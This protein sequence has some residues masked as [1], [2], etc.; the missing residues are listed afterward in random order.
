LES[1]SDRE[2]N[3]SQPIFNG[4]LGLQQRVVPVYR[5]PFFEALGRACRDGLSVFAG[6]PLPQENIQSAGRLEGIDFTAGEN[7]HLFDPS[8]PF[9]QCWQPGLLAWLEDR[10]P[11]VLVVEANPRYPTTRQ[12]IRWM[13]NRGRKVL[14]W[15][16]GAPPLDGFLAGWRRKSRLALLS[17]LD[18]LIAYS[19]RGALEYQALSPPTSQVFVAPNAVTF[20]PQHPPPQRLAVFSDRPKILFVGRL[21]ERKRI[22]LLFEACARLPEARQPDVWIV[23][24]GPAAGH[25]KEVAERLYPR[26]EFTGELHG[27]AL[28]PFLTA[29]DL[30]VLPGTGGLAVQQAMAHGLPVIVAQGDG[31]QDDLVRPENGWRVLPGDVN[32]LH[33][34]L[35]SALSNPQRLRRM[36]EASFRLVADQINIEAM[37]V[38]FIQAASVIQKAD[39]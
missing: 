15:G 17:K 19:R 11:D 29:A 23:G 12:A 31:T 25:F 20:Q 22:D 7:R 32:D 21:Q 36:G 28:E 27:Q 24:D 5:V 30:F 38:A 14:G 2:K 16:L 37:V 10:D 39:G 6:Q 18:G 26:A 8:S 9:Y 13:H 34:T 33:Q 1:V 4:K 3:V 35:E